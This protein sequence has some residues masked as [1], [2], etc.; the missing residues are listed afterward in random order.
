MHVGNHVPSVPQIIHPK[1]VLKH[2]IQ[3]MK[4]RIHAHAT[5][6]LVLMPS[7]PTTLLRTA[8]SGLTIDVRIG[9]VVYLPV[10]FPVRLQQRFW[11]HAQALPDT[12]NQLAGSIERRRGRDHR[13]RN[14]RDHALPNRLHDLRAS[15]L[16]LALRAHRVLV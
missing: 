9:A 2:G 8:L 7:G 1:H 14:D 13:Q 6:P 10:H 11:A 16:A 5:V 15:A 3:I 12:L 4:K